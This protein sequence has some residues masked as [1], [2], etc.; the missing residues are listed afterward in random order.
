MAAVP[1]SKPPAPP[2]RAA[3]E[4]CITIR[5]NGSYVQVE[6]GGVPL[7][8]ITDIGLSFLPGGLP[9][10]QVS[11]APGS[12]D[13]RLDD[14]KLVIGG[15]EMPEAVQRALYEHLRV[16]FHQEEHADAAWPNPQEM[17]A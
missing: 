13:I 17:E 3:T 7:R 15:H 1:D 9:E 12:C 2:P 11:M 6:V 16:R 14:A 4:G 8:F 10:V 5:H